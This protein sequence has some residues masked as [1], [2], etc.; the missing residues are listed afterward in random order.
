MKK[1][2]PILFFIVG[3]TNNREVKVVET[4]EPKKIRIV[5]DTIEYDT[6]EMEDTLVNY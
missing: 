4:P 2:I 1:L 6:Y 3:C 5:S